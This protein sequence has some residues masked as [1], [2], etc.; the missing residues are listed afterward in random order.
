MKERH[1]LCGGQTL[2]HY[3]FCFCAAPK[4]GGQPR[5]QGQFWQGFDL[6]K[7]KRKS[8]SIYGSPQPPHRPSSKCRTSDQCETTWSRLPTRLLRI[9]HMIRQDYPEN[10]WLIHVSRFILIF[11]IK[12]CH[13]HGLPPLTHRWRADSPQ[14]T[15]PTSLC[16]PEAQSSAQT[17]FNKHLAPGSTTTKASQNGML[18]HASK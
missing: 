12:N 6:K 3:Q 4:S 16:R 14:R 15:S 7:G 18:R 2:G 5:M 10:A 8:S 9:A 17:S 13:L 1:P 11:L